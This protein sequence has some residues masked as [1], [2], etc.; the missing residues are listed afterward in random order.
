MKPRHLETALLAKALAYF[1]ANRD[2]P[3][4]VACELLVRSGMRSHELAGI[5]LANVN[6]LKGLVY[7][8]AAKKSNNRSVPIDRPC[9]KAVQD[10]LFLGDMPMLNLSAES[11][12][13]HLRRHWS[14]LKFRIYG[15]TDVAH[16]NLH[17]LRATFA[18]NMYLKGGR[19]ILLVQE[20]LGHRSIASTMRYLRVVQIEE[21]T[22]DILKAFK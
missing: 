18:V 7:I 8:N 17:G 19:D 16:C 3:W 2:D 4:T 5:R 14:L 6:A 1:R 10:Y 15:E 9:L 13:R 21:R 11:F 12:K 20:L 22:S